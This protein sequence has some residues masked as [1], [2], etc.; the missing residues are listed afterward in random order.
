MIP[1]TFFTLQNSNV[2]VSSLMN[3]LNSVAIVTSS[4]QITLVPTI[5]SAMAGEADPFEP[6]ASAIAKRVK[7][8]QTIVPRRAPVRIAPKP[9]FTLTIPA[10]DSE[11]DQLRVAACEAESGFA[12]QDI[13][14]NHENEQLSLVPDLLTLETNKSS[15]GPSKMKPLIKIKNRPL[16]KSRRTKNSKIR[17]PIVRRPT[18]PRPPEQNL[19]SNLAALLKIAE[20]YRSSTMDVPNQQTIVETVSSESPDVIVSTPLPDPSGFVTT[21]TSTRR[22]SHVRQLN[23]EE[24][25]ELSNKP[26]E[27]SPAVQLK[28]SEIPWDLA[29]RNAFASPPPA[30]S[31]IF[32]T[33]KGKAKRK[34]KSLPMPVTI[35]AAITPAISSNDAPLSTPIFPHPPVQESVTNLVSAEETSIPVTVTEEASQPC[36]TSDSIYA[37]L[38]AASILHEMANTPIVEVTQR[39]T[40]TETAANPMVTQCAVSTANLSKFGTDIVSREGHVVQHFNLPVLATPLKEITD[41]LIGSYPTHSVPSAILCDGQSNSVSFGAWDGEIP[42]TPQIRMDL[43]SSTSPFQVSLTK[44]FRFLPAADSP[45]L[46]VPATPCILEAGNSNTSIE[47]PYTGFYQFPSVLSTPRFAASLFHILYL[48]IT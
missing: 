15:P 46:A 32:A 19:T 35:D 23:F 48:R 20:E 7:K 25:P 24:S 22:R 37:D 8:K 41:T 29:L 42:R 39:K 38:V 43:T 28:R 16:A 44:G 9:I 36:T 10:P 26:T 18:S 5:I 45:S 30:D 2:T 11:Y 17:D 33:P 47:T 40:T 21:P 6:V 1:S 31:D 3:T 27:N 13:E 14:E 12:E 4:G 34:R